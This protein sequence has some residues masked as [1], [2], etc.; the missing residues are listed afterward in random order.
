MTSNFKSPIAELVDQQFSK[1]KAKRGECCNN[2]VTGAGFVWGI[3][4][5]SVQKKEAIAALRA[6]EWFAINGP[7]DAPPLPLSHS[8]VD[9]Y[10]EARG[11]AGVVGFYARSL[12]RQGYDRRRYDVRN[13]PS[14]NDFARGLMAMAVDRGLRGLEQD[15]Q[16]K[17]RFPPRPLVGMTPGAY[18]AP[19]KEYAETMA[20]RRRAQSPPNE[21]AA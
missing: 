8:D 11:L 20:E 7:P 15:A 9:D 14:F 18:W 16:L 17:R 19:P 6:R 3:D 12:S 2:P 13:H 4:P 5:L 1:I 10:R 21:H